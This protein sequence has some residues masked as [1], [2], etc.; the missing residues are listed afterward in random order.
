MLTRAAYADDQHLRSRQ[1]IFA[2]AEA[3]AGPAW[4]ISPVPWDGTQIVADV[5]CG[6]GFDLRQLVPRHR[7]RHAFGLDLSAGMLRYSSCRR[8]RAGWVPHDRRAASAG[9]P[10]GEART[11]KTIRT[12]S[13]RPVRSGACSPLRGAREL[14]A[15]APAVPTLRAGFV[16]GM[17]YQ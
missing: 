8:D 11:P 13:P 3:P 4:R 9:G 16:N 7:C 5:G 14:R 15:A 17:S 2:Y 6:Y 10:A 1:A 12:C